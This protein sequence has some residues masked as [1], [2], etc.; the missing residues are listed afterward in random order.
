MR[1]TLSI[2]LFVVGCGGSNLQTVQESP[3]PNPG[4]GGF[5]AGQPAVEGWV[6]LGVPVE[7]T[8]LQ[9]TLNVSGQGGQIAQLLIK[10]VSGESEIKQVQVQYADQSVKSVDLNK[11]FLP[12]DGQVIEL[13]SDRPVE[14]IIIFMDA[15]STGTFEI[16]GA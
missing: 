10:G 1:K 12:G 9:R 8:P 7:E 4:Q 16:F 14:K 13:K 6:N 5:Q 2:A 3:R 15:N 11:R